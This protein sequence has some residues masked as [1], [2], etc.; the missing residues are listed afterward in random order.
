MKK[1]LLIFLTVIT[2]A[3]TCNQNDRVNNTKNKALENLCNGETA[4]KFLETGTSNAR[5][6]VCMCQ[7]AAKSSDQNLC[8]GVVNLNNGKDLITTCKMLFGK[9]GITTNAD[10]KICKE[11]FNSVK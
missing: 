7:Q 11:M 5:E 9:N 2:M 1:I 8:K 4:Q 6:Y 3:M 10:M